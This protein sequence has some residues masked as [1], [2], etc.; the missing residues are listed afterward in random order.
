M[1]SN[2]NFLDTEGRDA[3]NMKRIKQNDWKEKKYKVQNN[4]FKG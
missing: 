4:I 1:T 2:K 3:D